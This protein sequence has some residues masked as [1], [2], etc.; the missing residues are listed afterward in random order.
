VF[1]E[2]VV[3]SGLDAPAIRNEIRTLLADA[4]RIV[5]NAPFNARS[6]G[7]VTRT[8]E[9]QG[10]RVQVNDAQI[11]DLLAGFL[12]SA[13]TPVAVRLAA[14]RNY[15]QGETE[16]EGLLLPTPVRTAFES[17]ATIAQAQIDGE[18]SDARLFKLLLELADVGEK[19]ARERGVAPPLTPDRPNFY[20]A[21]TNERI[22]EAIRQIQAVKKSVQVRLVAAENLSTIEP[23]RVRFEVDAV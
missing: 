10:E 1:A 12:T 7:L 14:A 13:D 9:V 17:G 18:Q 20:A 16:L 5:R 21:G 3:P 11:I 22:F 2:R 19:A 4:N 15:V 8:F 23:L 6:I